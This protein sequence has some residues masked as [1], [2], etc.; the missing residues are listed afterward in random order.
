MSL[1]R[2]WDRFDPIDT[3][4]GLGNRRTR[5]LL[6]SNRGA[7]R[8]SWLFINLAYAGVRI[9]LVHGTV[10]RYGVNTALFAC[11]ELAAS[12]LNAYSTVELLDA[13]VRRRRRAIFGWGAAVALAFV[14]SDAYILVAGGQRL[15]RITV[16]VIVCWVTVTAFVGGVLSLRRSLRK[17][18]SIASASPL[19]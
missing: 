16:I 4:R 1:A 13:I 7:L 6:S 11:I 15:P 10:A 17:R 8:G 9:A 18:R 12:V 5:E 3:G 14:A 19:S 2:T